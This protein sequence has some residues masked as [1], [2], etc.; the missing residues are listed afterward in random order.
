MKKSAFYSTTLFLVLFLAATL[1]VEVQGQAAK[2]DTQAP[3]AASAPRPIELP[4]ILSW[5]RL[6][7]AVISNDG[8]FFAHRIVPNE[9]DGEIVLRRLKDGREWR[10]PIGEAAAVGGGDM[11]FSDDGKWFAF[12]S[13]PTFKEAKKLKKDRKPLQNKATLINLA[14]EQKTEFDKVRRFAFAGELGGWLALQKYGPDGPAAQ[15]ASAPGG[16]TPDR[17]TGADLILYEL[18]NG[19]QLNFGNVADFSFNKKGEWFAFTIDANEKSGNG[20]QAR[21]MTTGALLP[22]DSEKAIYRGL[23][24]TE[25]GD[26]LALVKGSEDK[27]YEDKLYSV[28]GVSFA[29]G[30]PQKT[31][32]VHKDDPS[33]PAGMTISPNRLA[34][35]TEDLSGFVFGIQD[36][37]K[38]KD[39]KKPD[40]KDAKTE[41]AAAAPKKP[42]D[43]PEKPD[44]VL[45]HWQDPRLQAQQ[46]VEENTDKNF[47]YTAT[48]RIGEK[49]FI[50]IADESIR[51]AIPQPKQRFAIGRDVRDYELQGSLD[52]RRYSD[53]YVVDMKTGERKPA[54]KKARATFA[55]SPDGTHF[56]YYEDGNFLTYDMTTG[57]SYNIT[58]NVASN[59][60]DEDNDINVVK[61]PTF[62]VGW[63]SDSSAV[64]LSDNWDIWKVPAHG[65]SAVNLTVNGKSDKIR[66]EARIQMDPEE[67]GIDLSQPIYLRTYGEWTK[68]AGVAIVENGKPGA[69]VLRWDDAMYGRIFKAKNA[70]VYLY[71]RETTM[72]A[73]SF[74]LT[75]ASLAD[76]QKITHTN[77]QQKNF[78][79]SS[80]AR[81]VNYTTA[82]GDKLQAALF[83]PA[84][85][86]PGKSYPTVVYIYEKLSQG[87]NSY[88]G[89]TFNGFNK[90][91]YTSNGYAVLMP[92]ITYKLDDPG[93]SALWSILPALKAAG[94]T[95]VV[96]MQHVAL[97]GHSWGGYQTAFMVTQT[98]AFRAAIAGAPLTDMISMYNL[99]YGNSGSGNMA[100]FESS[101]GRFTSSPADNPTAYIRNSPVFHAKNVKTPLMILHNDKDGAVDFTQ[102]I[103]YYN[104]LRR[105]QKPV[106]LLQ[107][108]GENHGL[109]NPANMKDYT[110]RMKEFLDYHLK[111][112]PA[113]KWLIEGIPLLKLKEHLEERAQEKTV[114]EVQP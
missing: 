14:S 76:G 109:R 61:P 8:Q 99:V 6:A 25:K 77:P 1:A 85:Y 4:D 87:L 12:A 107:Y 104:Q 7:G 21:N 42:E 5:K 28:V 110:I 112:A 60:F 93:M 82:K 39:E 50:R 63:T 73:P 103:E 88:S 57:Q 48:Y 105:L 114:V 74:Y 19:G 13:Y 91:V 26:A 52:G 102:G 86:E 41:P 31:T 55:T 37:K 80:G 32:Y 71:N 45:W 18:D 40:V 92:D 3:A 78:R 16:V 17:P 68:K 33:F 15:A 100:I 64:L 70:P 83:L 47:S 56:L 36:V 72:E 97:H 24:W 11:V 22:L 27:G 9:G 54:L 2:A 65:G 20:I 90:S 89:P 49:K 66:Y 35:W 111:G 67:K 79:W 58:K 51:V 96:D 75:D 43:E 59:F 84:D 34:M 95:G 10:F 44:L 106:V 53:V 23:N 69:K 46:Q 30:I 38:K 62:P 101:Q 29:S 108:K 98:D 113:P 81:L 94:E